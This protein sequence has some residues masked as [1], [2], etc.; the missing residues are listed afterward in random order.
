MPL[1]GRKEVA[2]GGGGPRGLEMPVV[3]GVFIWVATLVLF[4]PHPFAVPDTFHNNFK[5]SKTVT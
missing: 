5:K 4:L 3:F 2:S 1:G